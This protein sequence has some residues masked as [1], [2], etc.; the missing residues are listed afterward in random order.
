MKVKE[1]LL[2]LIIIIVML[3][4][5]VSNNKEG[6]V[7][8]MMPNADMIKNVR[9]V[10]ETDRRTILSECYDSMRKHETLFSIY[11]EDYKYEEISQ[12]PKKSMQQNVT[13]LFPFLQKH[14]NELIKMTKNHNKYVPTTTLKELKDGS[15]LKPLRDDLEKIM[16]YEGKSVMPKVTTSYDE[17]IKEAEA[18]EK[19]AA[20]TG[21]K[22]LR[23]DLYRK[24]KNKRVDAAKKKI[25]DSPA[26]NAN[27]PVDTEPRITQEEIDA[28]IQ[29]VELFHIMQVIKYQDLAVKEVYNIA[30]D[31]MKQTYSI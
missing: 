17:L 4:F 3:Y 29:F 28:R 16:N 1:I 15:L 12:D 21:W 31:Y 2:L 8:Y 14:D 7:D 24:A 30:T 20:R 22:E 10:P 6:Y 13:R 23:D 18:Y 27:T 5:G 19:E 9:V 25:E 11:D 26:D